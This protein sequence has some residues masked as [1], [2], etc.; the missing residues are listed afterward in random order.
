MEQIR[1]PTRREIRPILSPSRPIQIKSEMLRVDFEPSSVGTPPNEFLSN[2][3]K[4]MD[5]YYS[6]IDDFNSSMV[7]VASS[8]NRNI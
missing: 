8:D 7:S 1:L 5:V 2:L 6:P 3:K 4:R